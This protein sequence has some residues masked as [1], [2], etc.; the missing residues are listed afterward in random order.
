MFE[1]SPGG[2][3]ESCTAAFRHDK[4]AERYCVSSTFPRIASQSVFTTLSGQWR[5]A[6]TRLSRRDR[7][8]DSFPSSRGRGIGKWVYSRGISEPMRRITIITFVHFVSCQISP[9][10]R[11]RPE[12]QRRTEGGPKA[13]RRSRRRRS[14]RV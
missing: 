7:N 4:S 3:T 10:L 6:E 9:N 5:R 2:D 13:D 14:R 11:Q 8:R 12:D 1:R